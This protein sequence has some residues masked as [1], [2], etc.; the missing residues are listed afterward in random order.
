MI[1]TNNPHHRTKSL[2]YTQ[3]ISLWWCI[4]AFVLLLLHTHTGLTFHY[5][6]RSDTVKIGWCTVFFRFALFLYFVCRLSC[7]PNQYMGRCWSAQHTIH[8]YIIQTHGCC[9]RAIHTVWLD[10]VLLAQRHE[11]TDESS[12]YLWYQK[13]FCSSYVQCRTFFKWNGEVCFCWLLIRYCQMLLGAWLAF[14]LALS[15]LLL[16]R[17]AHSNFL[18]F[19]FQWFVF[20]IADDIPVLR[21]YK[22]GR[23]SDAAIQDAGIT[24]E[25]FIWRIIVVFFFLDENS[26]TLLAVKPMKLFVLFV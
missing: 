3:T 13:Y 11:W 20:M 17:H 25:R 10:T 12:A 5:M 4:G 16:V 2:A 14:G 7:T 8:R 24:D 15:I 19:S 9:E 6:H 26:S 1:S 18:L 22:K 21:Q 23:N